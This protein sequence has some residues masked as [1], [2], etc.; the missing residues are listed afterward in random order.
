MDYHSFLLNIIQSFF[1]SSSYNAEIFLKNIGSTFQVDRAYWLEPIQKDKEIYLSKEAIWKR[2]GIPSCE[3]DREVNELITSVFREHQKTYFL[4]E[5]G[6]KIDKSFKDVLIKRRVKTLLVFPFTVEKRLRGVLGL[7]NILNYRKWNKTEI[8]VLQIATYLYGL[9]YL[10]K[11]FKSNL[12]NIKLQFKALLNS[13]PDVIVVKDDKGRW[14]FANRA[15]IKYFE[16][17]NIDYIGKTNEELLPHVKKEIAKK[18]LLKGIETNKKLIEQKDLIK[19]ISKYELSSGEE[20]YL[21]IRKAPIYDKD[22]NFRGLLTVVKDITDDEKL[23]REMEKSER[24]KSLGL[25]A[26]SIAHDFNNLLTAIMGS[27]SLLEKKVSPQLRHSVKIIL[28]ASYKARELATQMLSYAGERVIEKDTLNLSEEISRMEAFLKRVVFDDIELK[29]KKS[30]KDLY[31]RMNKGQLQQILTNLV[32]NASDAIGKKE[33]K[34]VVKIY[35][36][37]LYEKDFPDLVIPYKFSEGEYAV[38]EVKDTGPGISE[39]II[40]HLFDPFFSTKKTG[41]G[42]GLFTV[43]S[44]IKTYNGAIKV[45]S[46][47]GRGTTF[48][49]YLPIH[50]YEEKEVQKSLEKPLKRKFFKILVVDDEEYVRDILYEMLSYMGHDVLVSESSDKALELLNKDPTV[51]IVITDYRMPKMTGL[52]LIKKI[53]EKKKDI[54]IILSSGYTEDDLEG[55][56]EERNLLFLQKPYNMETLRKVIEKLY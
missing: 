21:E 11:T 15:A 29:I 40:D 47:K 13:F 9:F 20:L 50:P 26:G 35:K 28:D 42:L 8:N 19:Y 12:D 34:I 1:Y 46:K 30:D 52:E 17:E 33:G 25:M 41:R 44:I 37:Y 3:F 38:I 49:I 36:E 24:L 14:M 10:Q 5:A 22:Y 7:E 55:V 23:R 27:A 43:F 54:K 39:D 32:V 56:K 31:V 2:E 16:L 6:D 45:S 48:K 51:D 53:R 18:S 4:I